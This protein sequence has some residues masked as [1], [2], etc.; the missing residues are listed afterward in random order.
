MSKPFR[1]AQRVVVIGASAGGIKALIE[2]L[3]HL[4]AELPAAILVVQH[5]WSKR[6]T[7]LHKLLSLHSP[8][9]ICL[10][11]DG[12]PLEEGVV[13]LGVPGYHLSLEKR[14]LVLNLE[15]RVNYV[16]P[17]IDVLFA[18]AAEEFG[19]N[20][21]GVIL[22]GSGVDG[23]YGCQRIKEKRGVTIA[24]DE[25]TSAFFGMSRAAI[26]VGSIDYVLPLEEIATKIAASVGFTL[27]G[28]M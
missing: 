11:Q 15:E 22:S 20:V 12:L 26:Y 16:R 25:K 18:A 14:H 10:A 27:N 7:Y 23:V 3:S 2:V 5:L 8:L 21:V 28:K 19:P 4:S 13:Y 6:P 1:E 17:S 9:S 24:Q